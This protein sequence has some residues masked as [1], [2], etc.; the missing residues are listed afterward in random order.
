[1]PNYSHDTR[2]EDITERP[3]KILDVK[4]VDNYIWGKT[5]ELDGRDV[6]R[7]LIKVVNGKLIYFKFYRE[8]AWVPMELSE[9]MTELI[10]KLQSKQCS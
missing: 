10:T 9:K 1:M 2:H 5:G 4:I 3:V 8:R 7:N 6:G